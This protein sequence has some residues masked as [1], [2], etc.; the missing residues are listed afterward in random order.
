MENSNLPM[1]VGD[2]SLTKN[3]KRIGIK[4][5]KI[6]GSSA[7]IVGFLGAF[8]LS[9]AFAPVLTIPSAIAVGVSAQKLLNNTKYKSYKDL[10]FVTR[11][12]NGKVTIGEDI[13]RL[14]LTTKMRNMSNIEKVA[15]MQLQTLVGLTKFDA[16]DK[17][18]ED[19]TF[20]TKTHGINQKTF[21][22]LQELGYIKDY[23]ESFYKESH[24]LLPK[25]AFLNFR[26]IKDYIM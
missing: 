25:L 21:K 12:H 17:N 24:L 1:K 6:L 5:A 14:D 3:L 20:E 4:T 22:K 11:E 16:K 15:F 7:A 13:T 2:K 18:G 9:V 19:L 10:A 23:E 8:G 26:G